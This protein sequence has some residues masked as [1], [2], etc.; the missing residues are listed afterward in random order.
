MIIITS[1]KRKGKANLRSDRD[2]NKE[3][4]LKLNEMAKLVEFRG[5]LG[6]QCTRFLFGG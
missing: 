5:S 1:K 3:E 6:K 4:K 2:T